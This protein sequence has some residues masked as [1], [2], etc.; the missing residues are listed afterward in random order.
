MNGQKGGKLWASSSD[1]YSGAVTVE[2]D[3]QNIF[4]EV[5]LVRTYAN[6]SADYF[7]TGIG[8]SQIVSNGVVENF[9][10]DYPRVVW[11]PNC[12]SMTFRVDT[13]RCFVEGRWLANVW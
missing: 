3:N 10:E 4:A 6:G 12:Q 5:A 8:I 7:F 1:V 2:M 13:Y 11:R 9:N